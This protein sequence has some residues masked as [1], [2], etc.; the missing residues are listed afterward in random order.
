MICK[1]LRQPFYFR[2][3]ACLL[4]F[5]QQLQ[6]GQEIVVCQKPLRHLYTHYDC[7]GKAQRL[8]GSQILAQH[9]RSRFCIRVEAIRRNL[10]HLETVGRLGGWVHMP[11]QYLQGGRGSTDG[12][13]FL[14]HSSPTVRKHHQRALQSMRRHCR[15]FSSRLSLYHI[16]LPHQSSPVKVDGSKD[17]LPTGLDQRTEACSFSQPPAHLVK[18]SKVK[19]SLSHIDYSEDHLEHNVTHGLQQRLAPSAVPHPTLHPYDTKQQAN[20]YS[21]VYGCPALVPHSPGN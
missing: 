7:S 20:P 13:N 8:E 6:C 18:M 17:L 19:C 15:S 14:R 2:L 4:G 12:R 21:S 3:F 10:G 16:K 1:E 5:D 11:R 9:H